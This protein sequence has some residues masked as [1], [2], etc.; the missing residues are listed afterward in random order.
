MAPVFLPGWDTPDEQTE[1]VDELMGE[2]YRKAVHAAIWS[3]GV[4]VFVGVAIVLPAIY[5]M[6]PV[7]VAAAKLLSD[8]YC[9][10][11]DP[12]M[13]AVLYGLFGAAFGQLLGWRVL[14]ATD[15]GGMAVWLACSAGAGLVGLIAA[16]VAPALL[17]GEAL[18][19][20]WVSLGVMT[21]AALVS[22]AIRI[23]RVV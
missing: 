14:G 22:V 12:L 21:G 18:I 16:A 17:S 6:R 13:P 4:M 3:A 15:L 7:F 9:G 20:C 2:E 23:L 5:L 19:V 8:D 11:R 1:S 10:Q